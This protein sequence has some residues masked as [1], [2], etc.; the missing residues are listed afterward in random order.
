MSRARAV[1]ADAIAAV[2]AAQISE[3]LGVTYT[4]ALTTARD[5]VHAIEDDGW[6]ISA[7]PLR[8]TTHPEQHP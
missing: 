5:A 1:I 3:A 4:Q 7:L 6:H 8:A 2:I